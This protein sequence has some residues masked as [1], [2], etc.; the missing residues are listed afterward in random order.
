[1]NIKKYF[2]LKKYW[3]VLKNRFRKKYQ[4]SYSQ[5]G[6]DLIV[7]YI[8][9]QL[10]IEKITYLDLG[11]YH[12][13]I[14]NNTYS[15]YKQKNKGVCVESDPQLFKVI[16]K[17]RK[18]DKCLNVGVGAS[19]KKNADF[20]IMS[21]RSLNT[22]SKEEAERLS[23]NEK[24]KIESIIQIPVISVNQIISENFD[25]YPNFISLDIEGLDFDVLKNFDF[26]KYRPEVFCIE[27]LTYS[28]YATEK[29][30]DNIIS[31]MKEKNYFVYADTYINTIFVCAEKWK[32][33][34]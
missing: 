29:K 13:H 4:T 1:M 9:K 20:Y 31:F 30:L 18:N 25:H 10:G 12:P 19:S 3:D 14:L 2:A 8:F 6:E 32:N 5:C 34:K 11:A 27:T 21:S 33:R 23:T 22:F 16:A 15:L 24:Q 28:E 26:N 7:G 17:F